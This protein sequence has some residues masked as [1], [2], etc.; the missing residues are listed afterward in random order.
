MPFIERLLHSFGTSFPF[1]SILQYFFFPP[2]VV[3]LNKFKFH[4]IQT[5][6]WHK[7]LK[8]IHPTIP[9]PY[10]SYVQCMGEPAN[11]KITLSSRL[12]NVTML[13]KAPAF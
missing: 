10:S 6:S 8:T 3:T 11:A 7:K 4:R 13:M 9:L 12:M 2:Y 1:L 5:V